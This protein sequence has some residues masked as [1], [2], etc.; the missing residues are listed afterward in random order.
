MRSPPTNFTKLGECC[1][2]PD[3]RIIQ[4]RE[5]F[6]RGYPHFS[7]APESYLSFYSWNLTEYDKVFFFGCDTLHVRN[8]T[9]NILLK[10][11]AFAAATNLRSW[12]INGDALVVQ[13]DR[14]VFDQLYGNWMRGNYPYGG[15]TKWFHFFNQSKLTDA[16]LLGEDN[17]HVLF[18]MLYKGQP[19]GIPLVRGSGTRE[20]HPLDVCDNN[21]AGMRGYCPLDQ[22]TMYHKMPEWEASRMHMLHLAALNGQCLN[23]PALMSWDA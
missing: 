12:Y 19:Q 13:P 2:G 4:Q 14:H 11:P 21:K 9:Q 7:Y 1:Y 23:N 16:Q 8:T 20:M 5:A 10:Y 3:G 17:Q 15:I 6:E 22:Y 18:R